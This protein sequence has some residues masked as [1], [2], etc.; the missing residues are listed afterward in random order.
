M[1]T[2]KTPS[3]S[4]FPIYSSHRCNTWVLLLD[5]EI[6]IS[7]I[8]VPKANNWDLLSWYVAYTFESRGPVFMTP[9]IRRVPHGCSHSSHLESKEKIYHTDSSANMYWAFLSEW[10]LQIPWDPTVHMTCW[11]LVVLANGP[12]PCAGHLASCRWLSG[13][14]KCH[15]PLHRWLG[16][17]LLTQPPPI[18]IVTLL[19]PAIILL[20]DNTVLWEGWTE[21][22]WGWVVMWESHPSLKFCHGWDSTRSVCD[23][24]FLK[25]GYCWALR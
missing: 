14:F 25:H 17:V 11:L 6:I 20:R 21:F 1:R 5:G 15:P 23:L 18:T 8:Q 16:F 24:R 13:H 12:L 9:V 7:E 10:Q 3:Q 19:I 2:S 4:D 22:V